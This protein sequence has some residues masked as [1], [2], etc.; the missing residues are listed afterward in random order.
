MAYRFF[1]GNR[2]LGLFLVFFSIFF[3]IE[4]MIIFIKFVDHFV[5]SEKKDNYDAVGA[6]SVVYAFE[7]WNIILANASNIFRSNHLEYLFNEIT[8]LLPWNPVI[9]VLIDLV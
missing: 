2:I 3:N 4:W 8:K 6:Y 7:Y 1:G 5:M 9:S